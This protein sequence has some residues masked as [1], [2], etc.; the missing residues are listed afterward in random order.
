M[1]FAP[2]TQRLLAVHVRATRAPPGGRGF[3][4]SVCPR[5]GDPAGPGGPAGPLRTSFAALTGFVDMPNHY[6]V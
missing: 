1:S 5:P 6:K 2:P 4:R 3:V